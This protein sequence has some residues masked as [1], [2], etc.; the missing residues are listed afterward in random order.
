MTNVWMKL[1]R[2]SPDDGICWNSQ[3]YTPD[4]SQPRS[5]FPLCKDS[6]GD[7]ND[8]DGDEDSDSDHH[9]C[10]LPPF[11]IDLPSL[12]HLRFIP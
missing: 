11:P 9:R 7:S 6:P 1:A 8:D 4:D 10:H 12:P 3:A 5:T 2:S